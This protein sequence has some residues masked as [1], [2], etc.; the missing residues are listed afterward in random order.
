[1][2]EVS[3]LGTLQNGRRSE[4]RAYGLITVTNEG[5]VGPNLL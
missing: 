2:E 5:G 3:A 4:G 1:M